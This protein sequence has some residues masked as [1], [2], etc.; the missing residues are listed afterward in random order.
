MHIRRFTTLA[1]AAASLAFAQ[2]LPKAEPR[3][4]GI[5]PERLQRIQRAL[6]ESVDRKEFAGINAAIVRRGKLA[7]FE[8]F[9]YSDL[10]SNRPMRPDTI[11]RIYSMTKP[12]AS[13]AVMMLY[14]EGRFLLDDPV[15]RFIPGSEKVRVLAR[16]DGDPS[17]TVG[18]D[19]EVNVR[20]LLTHTSGLSN[21]RA[22]RES[23]VFDRSAT[24]KDMAAKLP[25][26]PLAHQPGTAWRY[27]AS[28]DVLGYLVEVWSGQTFDV[29]L[30]ERVFRPLGMT[31]TAFFVPKEKLDRL[32][33][34]YMLN[35]RGQVVPAPSQGDPSRKP[36]FFSGGGGLY[37]TAADYLRFCQMLVNG[38]AL[39]GKR[40]LSPATVDYMLRNHLPP[41]VIPPDGPNGRKGYGFGL[42][43]AVLLDSASAET[44]SVE[45]EFNWGGMAGTFF[46][47]DR[48]NEL[49]GL[50][51]VQQPPF[52]APPSK[53]YKVLTY[54]ALEN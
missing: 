15:S 5:S 49:I 21:S 13:A 6:Q 46:W 44:L 26:V 18:L 7:W 11:F 36:T 10:E 34:V 1:L 27:G 25:T 37:S 40:L 51:L 32:A 17:E 50:W 35:D 43:G 52:V 2:G 30:E 4:V 41:S 53:R 39:D 28:I 54:Q 33:K 19:R 23:R 24:L 12:I 8:S 3:Q 14:E 42:G 16:E 20:D 45:G 22:Y 48:K 9:G 29:F 31:D 47:I 38:G